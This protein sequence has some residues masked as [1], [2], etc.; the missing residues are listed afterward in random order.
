MK[1]LSSLGNELYR[2]QKSFN[3]V[4]KRKVWYTISA[5]LLIV[6][7]AILGVRGLNLSIEFKGGAEFIAPASNPTTETVTAARN[8]VNSAGTTAASVTIVGGDKIRVQTPN[9]STEES[10]VV[11]QALAN[12]LQVNEQ[13]VKIQ[14]VGPTWGG[15]VSANAARALVVFLVLVAIFLAIYFE[16]PMA[17]AALVALAHD[18]IITVGIYSLSGFE[19]SPASVIGF[20]TILGYSLYDTVVVFDKVKENTKGITAGSRMTYSEA[21]NLGVNQTIVRSINT[22]IV[23]LLPVFAILLVGLVQLGSGTLTDLALSLFVGMI[24]GTFSSIFIATPF[25]AQLKERQPEMKA[26]RKR[27]SSRRGKAGEV[28]P[29]FETAPSSPMVKAAGPR[30]QRV[31]KT[32]S[33]RKGK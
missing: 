5:V 6:S 14:L 16:W 19:V 4:G 8:A 17:L 20:L 13:E 26:L 7:F 10:V 22:S 18:V 11:S 23:A 12:A 21:A 31:R 9:L 29:S 30:Q 28:E 32:R 25:L 27:V 3:I 2:G 24:V 15:E 33:A 1:N